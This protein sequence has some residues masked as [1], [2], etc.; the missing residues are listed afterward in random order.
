[1]NKDKATI[2]YNE[3]LYIDKVRGKFF[4]EIRKI[5]QAINT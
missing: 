5:I 1:M 3:A 4:D 2:E